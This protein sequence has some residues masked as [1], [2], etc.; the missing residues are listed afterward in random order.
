V[1]TIN[2]NN[3][4]ELD[5][6]APLYKW[7]ISIPKAPE[8][9]S[10]PTDEQINIRCT[11]A[12]MPK[13]VD[14]TVEVPLKEFTDRIPGKQIPEGTLTVIFV[15]TIDNVI[16]NWLRTWRL[17]VGDPETGIQKPRKE[18]IADILFTRRDREGNPIYAYKAIG[19]YIS[20]YDPV[21]GE[22]GSDSEVVRPSLT[23]TYMAF[24]E[25]AL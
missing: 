25:T 13:S 11:S 2:I 8:A 23:I 4:R 5:D 22:L 17:A 19:C 16:S 15:E 6:Y 10:F 3:I 20:D 9:V 21:G 18:V 12:E 24:T 7:D 14:E 1:A